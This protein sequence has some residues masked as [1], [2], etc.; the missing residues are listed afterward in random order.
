MTSRTKIFQTLI[1]LNGIYIIDIN[2]VSAK[3][4]YKFYGINPL[5]PGR[6]LTI[7]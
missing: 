6:H 1:E 4:R 7:S 2:P 3:G 5:R